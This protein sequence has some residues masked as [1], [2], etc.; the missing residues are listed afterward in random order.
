MSKPNIDNWF[1]PEENDDD[2]PEWKIGT[3]YYEAQGFTPDEVEAFAAELIALAATARHREQNEDRTDKDWWEV[4]YT[5]DG[6]EAT[7]QV[8]A[9]DEHGARYYAQAGFGSP[10]DITEVKKI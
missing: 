2:A 4:T 10:I 9:D 1:T 3:I 8:V 5:L 7:T 6:Q